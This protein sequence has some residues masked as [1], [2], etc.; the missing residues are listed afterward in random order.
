MWERSERKKEVRRGFILTDLAGQTDGI[1]IHI[2]ITS[3]NK[4]KRK[5]RKTTQTD[6]F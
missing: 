4:K 2:L 1:R 5:H 6:L 3:E